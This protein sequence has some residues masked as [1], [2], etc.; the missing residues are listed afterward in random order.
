MFKNHIKGKYEL[1]RLACKLKGWRTRCY[2]VEVGCR[3]FA[4][5]SLRKFYQELGLEGKDLRNTLA[6]AAECAERASAWLWLKRNEKW[7]RSS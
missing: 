2:A 1:L 3:G 5:L 6:K 4:G 7:V